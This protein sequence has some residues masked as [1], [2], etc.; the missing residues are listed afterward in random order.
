MMIDNTTEDKMH[1]S[2]FVLLKRFVESTGDYSTWIRLLEEAGIERSSYQMN[3]MYPT[4][5]LF[6]IV[7]KA[8][9]FTGIPTYDLMEK[10]GEFLVPDLL[11]V[12]KKYINPNWRT[13]DMLL[14]TELSMHG[15]VRREDS[16]T[17][18][19]MLVVTAEGDNQ[20]T[21][22]YSSKR[23]M[24]GVAVGIIRGIAKYYNESDLVKVTR[25]SPAD[26]EKVQ[27]RVDFAGL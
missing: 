8:S 18:P 4:E 6:S 2:I 5:E 20:L 24:A 26:E 15:A 9:E 19:P 13:Y 16:R 25:L 3:E 17:N 7:R 10:Y 27:I 23:R 21:I 22:E 14:N 11:L 12:Y 1:G